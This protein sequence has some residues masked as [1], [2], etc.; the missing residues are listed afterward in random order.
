MKNKVTCPSCGFE[1][2][3]YRSTC[4]SCKNYLR[5]RVAN[6][7]FWLTFALLIENP[8]KAFRNII[9]AEHKNFI[10]FLIL[11]YAAK[12]LINARWISLLTLGEF[13][14]GV[15]TTISY[16]VI[17]AFSLLYIAGFIIIIKK[18]WKELGIS[19]R[20]KD[21]LA[22][23]VYSQLLFTISLLILFPLEI[24]ILGD[25][26][27][28]VNPSPF[29]I[30]DAVAYIFFSMEILVILWSAFL[31]YKGFYVTTKS[32]VASFLTSLIF[33]ISMAVIL[34]F[35]SKIIFIF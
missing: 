6:L 14:P 2:D 24:L 3:F 10:L 1:N 7:D 4:S 15:S 5:D 31:L 30:K 23:I 9:Y 13:E 28:S 21:N 33:Y 12:L 8:V 32:I 29:Q 16:L 34:F 27:F 20:F 26:L 35:L 17:L 19:T 11:L 25:Y 18:V 22:V